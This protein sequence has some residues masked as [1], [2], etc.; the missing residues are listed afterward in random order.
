MSGA[1]PCWITGIDCPICGAWGTSDS[2]YPTVECETIAALGNDVRKFMILTKGHVRPT[3][4]VNIK[5][6][7]RPPM[8][9][10]EYSSLKVTLEP[11]L[12]RDRPIFP[13]TQLGPITATVRGVRG[14]VE[15]FL[16]GS[17]F[18]P[19]IRESVFKEIQD[20][21]HLISGNRA[22]LTFKKTEDPAEPLIELEIPPTARV[23][24]SIKYD[25]CDTCGRIEL[26]RENLIV[27]CTRFDESIPI[28]RIFEQGTVLVISESFAEFIRNRNYTGVVIEEQKS[29]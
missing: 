8:T 17:S 7:I 13:G 12:G 14:Q 4:L 25:L 24:S 3:G 26:A 5:K 11:L 9:V 22:I 15:D 10:A 16:W 1:T 27:D 28:Q 2:R 23:A 21:G 6:I 29:G 19:Y 18:V 20:A